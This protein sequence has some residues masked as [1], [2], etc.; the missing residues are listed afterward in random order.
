MCGHTKQLPIC[1]A[2]HQ[3]PPQGR[4]KE[5]WWKGKAVRRGSHASGKCCHVFSF[6]GC[7][8]V[9]T[10]SKARGQPTT[11]GCLTPWTLPLCSREVLVSLTLWNRD[12]LSGGS[13]LECR[14]ASSSPI[15]RSCCEV[16]LSPFLPRVLLDLHGLDQFQLLPGVRCLL[17]WL[18]RAI[19][20]V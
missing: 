12:P 18:T 14:Q 13:W 9:G 17:T 16:Y 10:A 20:C 15:I 8:G 11:P 1:T 2:E 7:L 5:P 6:I 4:R 3:T 19:H